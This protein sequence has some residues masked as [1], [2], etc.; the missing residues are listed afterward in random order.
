MID[1]REPVGETESAAPT[2]VTLTNV[3]PTNVVPI[4]MAPTDVAEADFLSASGALVSFAE[5]VIADG[6]GGGWDDDQA[7]AMVKK[8]FLSSMTPQLSKL[9]VTLKPGLVK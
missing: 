8:R 5:N 2:N 3:A 1:D 9:S 7:A 6:L 4:E